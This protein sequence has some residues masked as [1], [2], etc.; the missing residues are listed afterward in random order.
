MVDGALGQ[1]ASAVSDCGQIA[2][3][4]VSENGE[5][6]PVR[7]SKRKVI[8]S[9]RLRH[10]QCTSGFRSRRSVIAH[11]ENQVERGYPGELSNVRMKL[12]APPHS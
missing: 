1:P 6:R 2:N 8:A 10:S 12:C 11:P 7:L 5:L 3:G 4:M 9:D